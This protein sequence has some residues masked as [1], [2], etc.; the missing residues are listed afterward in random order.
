M[1][2]S[3][4]GERHTVPTDEDI[5]LAEAEEVA[6]HMNIDLGASLPTLK[7]M[8][9]VFILVRRKNPDGAIVDQVDAVRKMTLASLGLEQEEV[10]EVANPLPLDLAVNGHSETIPEA[11]GLPT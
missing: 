9:L 7:F 8:G 1:E 3:I 10:A 5:T 4:N 2:I 11:S 6:V